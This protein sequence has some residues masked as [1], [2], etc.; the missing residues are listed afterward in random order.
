[1][2]VDEIIPADIKIPIM[3]VLPILVPKTPALPIT[4]TVAPDK[5][6]DPAPKV[7]DAIAS[8]PLIAAVLR[9]VPAIYPLAPETIRPPVA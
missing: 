8:S 3:P 9:N 1:M 7:V 5:Y 2:G 6:N 4:L